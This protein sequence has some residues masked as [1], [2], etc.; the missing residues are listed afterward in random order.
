MY[1]KLLFLF[2]VVSPFI[3]SPKG[4]TP[5]TFFYSGEKLKYLKDGYESGN[6]KNDA[7]LSHLLRDAEKTLSVEVPSVVEKKQV[8]PS[9]D[10]HDYTSLG[11]YWW[12]DTTKPDGMPYI[13]KDGVTNPEVNNYT[14]KI[15][16]NKVIS[17]VNTLALGYYISGDEAY[18]KKAIEIL[19]KWF[20][21][22]ET[23]MNPHLEYSGFVPGRN[24]GGGKSG[25]ID[26]H[27][28]YLLVDALMLLE[29]SKEMTSD[30]KNG[31]R[32]W[33]S[34]YLTWLTHSKNGV[35]EG[36]S[37]NNHG[38]WYDVQVISL[39][40][41]AGQIDLAKQVAESAKLKRISSQVEYDGKQTFELQ[42]TNSWGYSNFNLVALFY[43]AQLAE[44]AGVD[45]WLYGDN[46]KSVKSALNYL[47]PF[48][49]DTTKWKNQ[50][51]S[52][53]QLNDLYPI[54]LIAEKKYHDSEYGNWRR[55]LFGKEYDKDR[56]N[57]FF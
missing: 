43:L 16:L 23:K 8:P 39:A 13:K 2:L 41:Y 6:L 4:G 52:A 1:N 25:L 9:G 17:S 14:D 21:S 34:E 5:G 46:G 54:L 32:L 27:R 10:K 12:P 53:F 40:F 55:K 22:P 51:I 24:R 26:T 18:A 28:I 42:R 48:A 47:L 15:Y 44:K 30:D 31:L 56:M 11:R 35:N 37:R 38:T 36:K 29:D 33:M 3:A 7:A 45:L 57:L 19:R 20:V 49:Q 50:Q